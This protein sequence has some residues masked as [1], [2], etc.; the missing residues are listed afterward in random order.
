MPWFPFVVGTKKPDRGGRAG[1]ADFVGES[2]SGGCRVLFGVSVERDDLGRCLADA[3]ERFLHEPVVEDRHR[4]AHFLG[5]EIQAFD[6]IPS[7]RR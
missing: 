6:Q 5:C 1:C 2:G 3:G 7:Q 4:D